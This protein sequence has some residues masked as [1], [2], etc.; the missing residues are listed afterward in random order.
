MPIGLALGL[1]ASLFWGAT[2]HSGAL[3]LVLRALAG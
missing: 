1:L 3:G 2:D